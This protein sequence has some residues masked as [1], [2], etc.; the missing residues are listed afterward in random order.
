M[1]KNCAPMEVL[2]TQD[3]MSD[4]Y[5]TLRI[6][7]K[8]Y[9]LSTNVNVVKTAKANA[10]TCKTHFI[11]WLVIKALLHVSKLKDCIQNTTAVIRD[12]IQ[13]KKFFSD[14]QEKI[15]GLNFFSDC[16]LS[17]TEFVLDFQC[18]F[19]SCL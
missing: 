1:D 8:Q 6:F 13:S 10:R 9:R 19:L 15:L 16:I 14:H 5:I 11:T 18:T 4:K 7:S 3:L 2:A 12:K 17:L